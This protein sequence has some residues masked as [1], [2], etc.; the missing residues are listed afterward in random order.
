[1][2]SYNINDYTVVTMH[3]PHFL[4]RVPYIAKILK[5]DIFVAL[6]SFQFTRWVRIEKQRVRD[7]VWEVVLQLEL[8]NK[9][10]I[11]PISSKTVI[12]SSI[13]KVVKQ[14]EINYAKSDFWNESKPIFVDALSELAFIEWVTLSEVNMMLLSMIIYKLWRHWKIIHCPVIESWAKKV[15]QLVE[16]FEMI[17][18]DF[19]EIF[20]DEKEIAFLNSPHWTSEYIVK[21]EENF[22]KLPDIFVYEFNREKYNQKWYREFMPYL[23]IVDL[24]CNLW[25]EWAK[26]YMSDNI[27]IRKF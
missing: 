11:E 20:D 6:N 21:D 4:P 27:T 1:M 8:Q 15:P 23:S 5:S 22:A 26:K 13:A 10:A 16:I 2:K 18:E 14:I 3:Q 7:R 24:V 9:H 19:F 12:S 25:W 17:Q